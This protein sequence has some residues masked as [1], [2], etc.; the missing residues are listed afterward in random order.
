MK[1]NI[2]VTKITKA[3]I[4]WELETQEGDTL[5][6]G[7]NGYENGEYGFYYKDPLAYE[8][9]KG[10]CYIPEAF[11]KEI[12]FKDPDPTTC[13]RLKDMIYVCPEFDKQKLFDKVWNDPD[14]FPA[15]AIA[16][17]GVYHK[18]DFLLFCNWDEE[19]AKN[20]FDECCWACPETVLDELGYY[21][22]EE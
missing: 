13:F 16:D 22:E 8:T 7:E 14:E 5:Y 6:V 1:T 2:T 20:F 15:Y 10:I 19:E 18:K 4:G 9:G 3:Y 12:D 21:D 17:P 11:F